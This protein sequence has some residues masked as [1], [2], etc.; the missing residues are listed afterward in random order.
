M[1]EQ[2]FDL[3]EEVIKRCQNLIKEHNKI[4]Y[5]N[6]SLDK[7][8]IELKQKPKD[9]VSASIK[10]FFEKYVSQM[11]VVS[12]LQNIVDSISYTHEDISIHIDRSSDTIAQ[13]FSSLTKNRFALTKCS[14]E[15][16]VNLN[17]IA[18]AFLDEV[19]SAID[20]NSDL[21]ETIEIIG[22]CMSD[23]RNEGMLFLYMGY[24]LIESLVKSNFLSSTQKLR[25]QTLNDDLKNTV[26]GTMRGHVDEPVKVNRLQT[27]GLVP[28]EGPPIDFQSVAKQLFGLNID[29][30]VS[31][32]S[33]IESFTQKLRVL[34][35]ESGIPTGIIL[36]TEPTD[37]RY[38][39]MRE[40]AKVSELSG[41]SGVNSEMVRRCDLIKE[42][43]R[44]LVGVSDLI[45]MNVDDT[46]ET[47]YVL[48][49]ND[50]RLFKVRTKP[51]H[52]S[53]ARKIVRC[54]PSPLVDTYHKMMTGLIDEAHTDDAIS[55]NRVK[56]MSIDGLMTEDS[57]LNSLV[58]KLISAMMRLVGKLSGNAFTKM[59]MSDTF[60][61]SVLDCI[62]DSK[63][64]LGIHPDL[65]SAHCHIIFASMSN[66]IEFRLRK[67]LMTLNGV[68]KEQLGEILPLIIRTNDNIYSRLIA[69]Y[70][71]QIA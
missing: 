51:I 39:D 55:F 11:V 3:N 46:N 70:Y 50:F 1:T 64:D 30:V 48:W 71:L 63:S 6:V 40:L 5:K 36:Y 15:I 8:V 52:G 28:D 49:T 17:S 66:N 16:K 59:V 61:D 65:L 47:A 34:S 29:P 13:L 25:I 27:F 24:R 67:D 22:A 32:K 37:D 58:S 4:S 57:F 12:Q 42:G 53:L 38:F 26:L 44:A 23:S 20:S 18:L 69:S 21:S 60:T 45:L 19:E 10:R 2:S 35:E 31:L 43:P 14:D 33:I 54:Y 7:P 41:S 62:N 56:Y 9:A 68:S